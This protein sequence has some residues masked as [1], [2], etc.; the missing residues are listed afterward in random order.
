MHHPFDLFAKNILRD[1][2]E[3]SWHVGDGE[4]GLAAP[5]KIDVYIVPDPARDR[6]FLAELGLL[7][8][9]ATGPTLFEPFHDTP[10]FCRSG[11]V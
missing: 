3:P 7:G 2:L 8:E 11:A 1:A 5:Q 10:P 6:R 9:L 4:R